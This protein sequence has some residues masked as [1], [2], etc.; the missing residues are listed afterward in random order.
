MRLSDVD[1]RPGKVL[2]VIDNYGTIKAS[3][4]GIFSEK[5]D[6][7][8]LPPVIPFIITSTT[9]FSMPHKDDLVWVWYNPDNPQELFY[10]FRCNTQKLN[11][12]TLD[13]EYP[14][15]EVQMKRKSDNGEISVEYNDDDGYTV[16]NSDSKFNIDNK[17]HDIHINHKGG[18]SVSITKD[19]ISLGKDGGSQYRA[20]CGEKLIDSLNDIKNILSAIKEAAIG[21]PYTMQIGTAMTPLM[22]KLENFKQMLS[23]LVTLEK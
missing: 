6:P 22:P 13:N 14:D 5:D 2:K 3:A 19:N 11:G 9:S 1:L 16:N 18:T 10:S 23:D 4:Q 21:N 7:D 17:E 12:G 15:V 8:M 20:V